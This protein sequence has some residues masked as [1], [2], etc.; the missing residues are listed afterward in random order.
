MSQPL[1]EFE[2]AYFEAALWS[3]TD[4]DTME[5]LDDLADLDD[6]Q[7]LMPKW[8]AEQRRDIADFREANAALLA[9]AGDDSQNGHD[10]WLTREGHGAGFWD[11]GYGAVGDR[12]SDASKAYGTAG[13]ELS[14][15]LPYLLA[16][17]T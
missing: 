5:P 8:F 1:D 11:R 2:E 15:E 12:L 4:A 17:E 10:F 6:V 14:I 7:R 16:E 13:D 3:T 9:K